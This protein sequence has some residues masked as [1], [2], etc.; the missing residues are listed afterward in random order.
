LTWNPAWMDSSTR[1]LWWDGMLDTMMVIDHANL[2]IGNEMAK[3]MAMLLEAAFCG[4]RGGI[5]KTL[6]CCPDRVDRTCRNTM[7]MYSER[8]IFRNLDMGKYSRWRYN[9]GP[10]LYSPRIS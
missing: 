6:K 10:R 9:L 3:K 7:G 1:A 5:Y 2:V 8:S 4:L